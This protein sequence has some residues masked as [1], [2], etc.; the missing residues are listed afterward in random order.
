[1]KTPKI[2]GLAIEVE[3]CCRKVKSIPS[4]RSVK[5][6]KVFISLFSLPTMAHQE[7]QMRRAGS[8]PLEFMFGARREESR[9]TGL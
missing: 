7:G 3:S 8:Q 1:M 5:R 6:D 2:L 9:F 4:S